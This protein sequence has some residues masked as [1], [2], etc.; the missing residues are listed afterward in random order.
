MYTDSQS[1]IVHNC[2]K[3]I[4]V[5]RM[6]ESLNKCSIPIQQYVF[7]NSKECSIDIWISLKCNMKF[8]RI[9]LQKDICIHVYIIHILY[10]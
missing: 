10:D 2:Q 9:Q 1:N 7:S 5:S 6:D 3:W 4:H 8:E